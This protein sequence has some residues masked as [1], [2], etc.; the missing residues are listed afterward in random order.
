MS[1]VREMLLHLQNHSRFCI[2]FQSVCSFCSLPHRLLEQVLVRNG[3]I[4]RYN[5]G[6]IDVS[7]SSYCM[8]DCYTDTDFAFYGLIKIQLV[9]RGI[10]FAGVFCD[11]GSIVK[12]EI[13]M[14]IQWEI[15]VFKNLDYLNAGAEIIG[16]KKK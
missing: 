1:L 13:A 9:F 12:Y 15:L 11:L 14:H 7:Q 5:R 16:C 4:G 10:V 3:S 6:E 8:I 2:Y